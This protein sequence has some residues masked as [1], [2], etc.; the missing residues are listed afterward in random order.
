V[1]GSTDTVENL[2]LDLLEFVITKRLLAERIP[3][4]VGVDLRAGR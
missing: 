3:R 4:V 1:T 2:I